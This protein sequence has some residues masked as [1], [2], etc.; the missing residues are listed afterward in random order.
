M[1]P[2][3]TILLAVNPNESDAQSLIK[4]ACGIAAFH[5]AKLHLA[6]V[7]PGVGDHSYNDIEFGLAEYGEEISEQRLTHLASLAKDAGYEIAAF[8]MARGDVARQVKKLNN[9][10]GID[11][12]ISGHHHHHMGWLMGDIGAELSKKLDRDLL[13]IKA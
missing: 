10:L 3:K 8:H 7:E 9:E 12:V 4:K 13:L 6:Y 1:S 2:Y 5:Q 11:L